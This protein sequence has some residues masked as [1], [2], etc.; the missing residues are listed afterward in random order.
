MVEL[1]LAIKLAKVFK[2]EKRERR[3][4]AEKTQIKYFS[5]GFAKKKSSGVSEKTDF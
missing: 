4:Q 5:K 2:L 1:E 3:G